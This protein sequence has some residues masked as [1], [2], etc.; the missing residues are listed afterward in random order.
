MYAALDSVFLVVD[1]E[2]VVEGE[3]ILADVSVITFVVITV[4]FGPEGMVGEAVTVFL[5]SKV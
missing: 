2:V 4:S 5:S 3:M 1:L